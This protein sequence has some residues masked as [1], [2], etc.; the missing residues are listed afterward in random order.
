VSELQH[1]GY[2]IPTVPDYAL[3]PFVSTPEDR[4]RWELAV[5]MAEE[6]SRQNESDGRVNS[7]FVFHFA[8]TVYFSELPTGSPGDPPVPLESAQA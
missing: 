2:P 7:Q 6:L 1:P 4:E 8:R 3:P 5:A